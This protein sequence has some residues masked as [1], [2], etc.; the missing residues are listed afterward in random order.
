MK[1]TKAL[2][3]LL[4]VITLGT[5]MTVTP[6]VSAQA[7]AHYSL[8]TT[9]KKLRGTWYAYNLKNKKSHYDT[10]KV[11]SKKLTETISGSSWSYALHVLNLKKNPSLKVLNS[12]KMSGWSCAYNKGAWTYFQ[13]WGDYDKQQDTT[14]TKF[15]VTHKTLNGHSVKTLHS[16]TYNSP[17]DPIYSSYYYKTK[18]LAKKANPKGISQVN[19]NK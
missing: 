2:G 17:K 13:A 10:V 5:V 9:P 3:A 18:A 19:I 11:A 8:K 7:K 4:A 12:V 16:I 6:D 1:M 15:Q 14:Y